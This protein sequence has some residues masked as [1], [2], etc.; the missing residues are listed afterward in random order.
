MIPM[1]VKEK[2]HARDIEKLRRNMKYISAER[3]VW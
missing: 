3:G 1:E 2:A